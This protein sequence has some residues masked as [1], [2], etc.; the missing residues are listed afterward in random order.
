VHDDAGPRLGHR[1]LGDTLVGE[2]AVSPREPVDLVGSVTVAKLV[3]Q[4][5]ADE[6]RGSRDQDSH[7]RRVYWRA[8]GLLAAALLLAGCEDG[9]RR[10]EP[11]PDRQQS[12]LALDADQQRLVADYQPVSRALTPYEIDYREWRAGRI[13]RGAAAVHA[14]RYR[15]VVLGS[16]RRV[17]RDHATGETARAKRL[18]VAAL[19]AR[20]RA[21]G[22]QPGSRRYR[23]EWDRSIVQARRGLTLLQE[24]RDRAGL[25]PLPED[26]VS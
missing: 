25:I 15:R 11:P 4:R 5:A 13:D 17:R 2:V 18:L 24:I 7:G 19:L 10:T 14:A 3:D 22:E 16:L 20:G 26:S 21:L 8:F 9:K 12:F 6:A 1:R 23:R